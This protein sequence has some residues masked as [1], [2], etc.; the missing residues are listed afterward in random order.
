[1]SECEKLKDIKSCHKC[2][3]RREHHE[4]CVDGYI[5]VY[6]D[7]ETILDALKWVDT[8]IDHYKARHTPDKALYWVQREIK[9]RIVISEY[10]DNDGT[11][12]V[13]ARNQLLRVDDKL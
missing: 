12:F 7:E 9:T 8:L 13:D 11:R 6:E 5:Q 1:M 4:T 10:P 2:I 3:D